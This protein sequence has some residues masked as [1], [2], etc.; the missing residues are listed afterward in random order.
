MNLVKRDM[1]PKGLLILLSVTALGLMGGGAVIRWGIRIKT[2]Q[3][4]DELL[5]EAMAITREISVTQVK[6]LSF[7][8]ADADRI[9]YQRLNHQLQSYARFIGCQSVYC[10]SKRG[11]NFV[12]GPGNLTG[13]DDLAFPPGTFYV[14]PPPELADVF[15]TCQPLLSGP[16]RNEAGQSVVSAWVPLSDPG[17]EKI[18]MVVGVTARTRLWRIHYACL[19]VGGFLFSVSLVACVLFAFYL[20]GKGRN[21]SPPLQKVV[22]LVEV[23]LVMVVGL[24]FTLTMG[25]MT[26]SMER[27]SRWVKFQTYAGSQAK[28]V[29]WSFSS[30]QMR[31][32][33]LA[34]LLGDEATVREEDFLRY[35]LPITQ[36]GIADAWAWI[37]IVPVA[38]MVTFETNVRNK[39][40]GF[41]VWQESGTGERIPVL[42]RDVYYPILVCKSATN[43]ARC[44]GFDCG[45]DPQLRKALETCMRLGTATGTIPKQPLWQDGENATLFVF[46]PVYSLRSVPK[47]LCGFVL[48]MIRP[49]K[50][51]RNAYTSAGTDKRAYVAAELVELDTIRPPQKFASASRFAFQPVKP[52]LLRNSGDPL[53]LTLPLFHFGKAYAA[54]ICAESAYY[55]NYPL[56]LGWAT[57]LTGGVLTVLLAGF[58]GLFSNRR[59]A[60]EQQVKTRTVEL[61]RLNQQTGT[62]LDSAVD[63]IL[64]VDDKG[65][66]TVVNVSASQTL[67][68]EI[69]ELVGKSCDLLWLGPP[70]FAMPSS[71]GANPIYITY[72]YGTMYKTND[73]VFYR[74]NGTTFH[75]SLACK[76]IHV[77]GQ[78]VGAVITFEDITERKIAE[79]KLRHAYSEL[80]S[81]NRQLMEASQAKNQ[82]LAHMSHEIR[83]P[84][85][86]VIGMGGLLI[87]TPLTEE[88]QEYAETIRMSG[89]SLLSIVNEILDFSKIEAN[90][91]DLE[92]QPFDLRHCVEDAVD[93]IAP[94]AAAKDLE[95]IYQ[96]DETLPAAWI[97]DVTRLRQILVNLLCNAV[98]FTEK[99]EV[100]VLVTGEKVDSGQ[101][102]LM[103]RV[104]DTGLGIPPERQDK[105]FEAFHQCDASTTRRFGGTGLGLAISKRLCELMGGGMTVE[106]SGVAGCGSTF[107]FS[108][109]VEP[110]QTARD[111]EAP[112]CEALIGK[113]VLIVVGKKVNQEVLIRQ[114]RIFGMISEAVS[115]A[116][117]ALERLMQA[118]LFGASGQFDVV[119]VDAHLGDAQADAKLN[120][121]LR[122][123]CKNGQTRLIRLEPLRAHTNKDNATPFV[124]RLTKPVKLSMLYNTLVKLFADQTA[125][126]RERERPQIFFDGEMAKQHPL[127]ILLAEDNVINQKVAL[128][129]LGKLGYRADVVSNGLEALEVVKC[130]DYDLV[131]MDVQMPEMDGEDA[132]HRIREEVPAG[133]QPW[134][135]AMTAN[136]MKED[137][138]RYQASGMNDYIP[139][140]VRIEHLVDVLLSVQPLSARASAEA[141]KGPL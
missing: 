75:V 119:I 123:L 49:D 54:I 10:V 15:R 42:W 116:H 51:L 11:G 13:A 56:R 100:E 17:S 84:L 79:G 68:Y 130:S 16:Y 26:R 73:A 35:L 105:L 117:E 70:E 22:G 31:M 94:S 131:F 85:N 110:D 21:L 124:E 87:N 58:V 115:T 74:K 83:T 1:Y 52:R 93:L 113:R 136:V 19:W 104:R 108:V 67:G 8:G 27:H 3:I 63:G 43:V 134:I 112:T 111:V 81:V 18:L 46:Q 4:H 59:I 48:V 121:I 39:K 44:V 34:L 96:I 36:T 47:T 137:R 37:P 78:V 91:I 61:A 125:Q 139:K 133:R 30:L 98:K 65:V 128:H 132:A 103:F 57:T 66:L 97:G 135:V 122:E 95:V 60:L 14:N 107:S 99:G 140:P 127:R 24:V 7:T 33:A 12:L 118:D 92:K 41:S 50:I 76:A 86:C 9:E 120:D 138:D 88:Q 102:R 90:K 129:I 62:I 6:A 53:H 77:H 126:V 29:S 5:A 55:E 20:A 101:T 80:E 141:A 40:A 114:V 109:V 89:E 28:D 25:S 64:G 2:S 106:S 69:G 32:D 38:D 23:G 82:F 71:K 45:A 72:T